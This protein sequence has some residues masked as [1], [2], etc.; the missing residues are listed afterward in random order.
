MPWGRGGSWSVDRLRGWLDAI[1]AWVEATSG[2]GVCVG[3]ALVV[4][5]V[6]LW[7]TPYWSIE[8]S[9][10]ALLE[11]A[12]LCIL[13]CLIRARPLR[14][15]VLWVVLG[16]FLTYNARSAITTWRLLMAALTIE[17]IASIFPM[18]ELSLNGL[19]AGVRYLTRGGAKPK[20]DAA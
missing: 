19:Q 10:L 17:V 18:W 9:K 4:A 15:F 12:F 16:Y 5:I 2:V 3:A 8:T 6:G 7:P 20:L 11:I 14:W 13:A 1:G